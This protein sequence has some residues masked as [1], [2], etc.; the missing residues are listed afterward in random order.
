MC[1]AGGWIKYVRWASAK[2]NELTIE[3]IEQHAD[4]RRFD[5]RLTLERQ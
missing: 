2:A 4:G 3:V 5:R 1:G